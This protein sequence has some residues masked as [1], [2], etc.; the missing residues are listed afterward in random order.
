LIA[1]A[2]GNAENTR[3]ALAVDDQGY[4][5]LAWLDTREPGPALRVAV[6]VR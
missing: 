1:D 4:A 6:A 3:P 5:Y 2:V